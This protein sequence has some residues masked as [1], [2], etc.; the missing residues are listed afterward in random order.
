MCINDREK[1]YPYNWMFAILFLTLSAALLFTPKREIGDCVRTISPFLDAIRL[2]LNC[3]SPGII[4]QATR[5]FTN[6]FDEPNIWGSRPTYI[7][8]IYILSNIFGIALNIVW[9]P[10][11]HLIISGLSNSFSISADEVERIKDL[12][13]AGVA[14]LFL[15]FFIIIASLR[16]ISDVFRFDR[17]GIFAAVWIVLTFD[18][19]AAWMWVPHSII[20]SLIVPIGGMLFFRIGIDISQYR[21]GRLIGYGFFGAF[22]TLFYQYS[23]IWLP[24]FSIGIL[25]FC[26]QNRE[27]PL[28]QLAKSLVPKYFLLAG[29]FVVPVAL[30]WFSN[31]LIRDGF[32][33]ELQ[34]YRQFIWIMDA[35]AASDLR[36]EL[37]RHLFKFLDNLTATFELYGAT[38]LLIFVVF[39]CLYL[40]SAEKNRDQFIIFCSVISTAGVMLLFN[41]LQGFYQPR[42]VIGLLLMAIFWTSSELIR[43]YG[44]RVG[45]GFMF[46]VG[47]VQFTM[48]FLR[49]AITQT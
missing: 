21:S 4:E 10:F 38:I 40:S 32:S 33:T 23:I 44:L 19:V 36:A 24:L 18:L 22:M 15:N 26:F 9:I 42:L 27:I 1:N 17:W 45:L 39:I 31:L 35:I 41:F 12:L 48:N 11:G 2:S 37:L 8:S 5:P 6:L 30:W 29:V 47:L 20:A 25:T 14:A 43:R 16:W 3:D 13:S 28:R 34:T 49:P 7:V 46:S